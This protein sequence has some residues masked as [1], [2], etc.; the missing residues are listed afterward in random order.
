[1]NNPKFRDCYLLP[2]KSLEIDVAVFVY[3]YGSV[4]PHRLASALHAEAQTRG[5]RGPPFSTGTCFRR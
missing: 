3:A 5:V 2:Q 4:F 1:M